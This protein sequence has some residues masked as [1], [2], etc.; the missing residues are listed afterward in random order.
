MK[1]LNL[2]YLLLFLAVWLI[3]PYPLAFGQTYDLLLKGGHVIDPKNNI[4]AQMDVAIK[5]GRIAIVAKGLNGNDAKKM[6]DVTGLYITPGL[7]DLHGHHFHGTEP[8]KYLSNSF[9]ALPTDG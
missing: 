1:K 3:G 4:D 2:L 6:V 9:T 5:E 7:I 8:N